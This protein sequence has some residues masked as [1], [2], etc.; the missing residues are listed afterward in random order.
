L[1]SKNEI[2]IGDLIKKVAGHRRGQLGTVVAEGA[3]ETQTILVNWLR[4]Q[5]TKDGGY[6]WIQKPGIELFVEG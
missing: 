6:E 3:D 5:Y 2:N 1:K 4:I